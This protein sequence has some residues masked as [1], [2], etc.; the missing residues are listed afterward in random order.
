MQPDGSVL[1]YAAR[2]SGPPETVQ[3][4]RN[5]ANNK[6]VPFSIFITESDIPEGIQV[7]SLPE[8]GIDPYGFLELKKE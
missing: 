5:Q 2:C 7:I 8:G 4:I 1:R 6:G 3:A